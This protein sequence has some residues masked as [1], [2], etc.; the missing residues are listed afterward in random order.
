L[1]EYAWALVSAEPAELRNPAQA[2]VYVRR[3]IDRAGAPNPVYL[4]T[5]GTAQFQSG[6]RG[7]AVQTLEEALRLMPQA[8]NGPALGLRKQIEAD[9]G[10]FKAAAGSP[11]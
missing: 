1:N 9:L 8:P 3:A 10:R 5:L 11:R 6:D 7:G 2:V 4:H